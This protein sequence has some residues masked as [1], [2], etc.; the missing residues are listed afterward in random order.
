MKRY[1]NRLMARLGYMPAAALGALAKHAS[2]PLKIEIDDSQVRETLALLE[3][4]EAAA[5]AAEASLDRV[6][7]TLAL[8]AIRMETSVTSAVAPLYDPATGLV[9]PSTGA[10]AANVGLRL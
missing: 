1:I 7:P 9:S 10:T 5:L 2:I 3:R 6:S 4:V 8:N